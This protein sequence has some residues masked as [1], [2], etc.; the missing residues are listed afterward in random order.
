MPSIQI[1][2]P[3]NGSSVPANT[4]VDI[5][6]TWDASQSARPGKKDRK[7]SA[8]A[9]ESY[10]ITCT[11]A[12]DFPAPTTSGTTTFTVNSG[13]GG[14]KVITVCLYQNPTAGGIIPFP[15][16]SAAVTL[17]PQG[18][19]TLPGTIGGTNPNPGGKEARASRKKYVCGTFNTAIVKNIICVTYRVEIDKAVPRD[20]DPTSPMF[21]IS[22]RLKKVKQ[23]SMHAG[24]LELGDGTWQATVK[25][26]LCK[27][28]DA[29]Q[30]Q[31]WF[32]DSNWAVLGTGSAALANVAKDSPCS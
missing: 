6:V 29:Y 19:G 10:K 2:S 5:S 30:I 14:P 16:A 11:D 4:N 18:A 20:G 25:A 22:Y 31:V 17:N 7:R 32:L 23:Y 24:N 3:A 9:S 15:L 13:S 1:N 28:K 12:T 27:P 21:T 8:R 26:D